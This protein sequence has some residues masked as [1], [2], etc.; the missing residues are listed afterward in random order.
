MPQIKKKLL[1]ICGLWFWCWIRNLMG[2]M[3]FVHFTEVLLV[4]HMER[5]ALVEI[6]VCSESNLSQAKTILSHK[7][8]LYPVLQA[9]QWYLLF[10][11]RQGQWSLT[12]PNCTLSHKFSNICY[13]WMDSD[14]DP[15]Q[16]KTAQSHKPNHD[17]CYSWMDRN[18]MNARVAAFRGC[19]ETCTAKR[20]TLCWSSSRMQMTMPMRVRLFHQ[21]SFSSTF[22]VRFT[23]FLSWLI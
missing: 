8:K 1:I 22:R 7:P 17:I 21:W 18:N 12:S 5:L 19:P 10:L 9:W 3:K 15:L 4:W 2:A 6:F 14:H 16:T 23:D 20:L 13:S 11:N